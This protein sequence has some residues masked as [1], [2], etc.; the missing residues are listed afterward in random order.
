MN[1]IIYIKHSLR[2]TINT[3]ITLLLL[4]KWLTMAMSVSLQFCICDSMLRRSIQ[5][6]TYSVYL[7]HWLYWSVLQE[8]P[9]FPTGLL[10][11]FPQSYMGSRNKYICIWY[12]TTVCTRN[13]KK[14]YDE[15]YR[16]L[17]LRN[18]HAEYAW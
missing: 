5:L 8:T 13:H 9:L 18:Y 12:K 4:R 14:K 16:V 7:F 10:F 6:C 15:R 2:I 1:D 3:N 11:I 17:L